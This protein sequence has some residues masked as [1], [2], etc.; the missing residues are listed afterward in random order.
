MSGT[1]ESS[2]KTQKLV[3]AKALCYPPFYMVLDPGSYINTS[4]TYSHNA[5]APF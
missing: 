2:W 1:T 5:T 4:Y 3:P